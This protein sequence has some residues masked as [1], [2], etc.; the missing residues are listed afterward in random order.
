MSGAQLADDHRLAELETVRQAVAECERKL[1]SYRALVDA[2]SDPAVV[3]GWIAETEAKRKVE[4]MR[5]DKVMSKIPKRLTE[6]EIAEMVA[7]IGDIRRALRT[8]DPQDKAEVYGE[9]GLRLIYE[10]ARNAVIAQAELGRSCTKVCPRGDT[11][12]TYMTFAASTT[13]V[14][15]GREGVRWCGIEHSG[16]APDSAHEASRMPVVEH[17]R[18]L[19]IQCHAVHLIPSCALAWHA[20]VVPAI[21]S[22]DVGTGVVV[23]LVGRNAQRGR[24]PIRRHRLDSSP[25]SPLGPWTC[26]SIS[27][28]ASTLVA[29]PPG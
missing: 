28:P 14:L 5:L 12:D 8:A 17:V 23:S 13:L 16:G 19:E 27:A 9:L 24:Q 4:Q 29:A 7:T 21:W 15:P 11:L 22:V 25:R 2:G 20:D 26:W 18:L 6:E 1:T 10:P 3:V